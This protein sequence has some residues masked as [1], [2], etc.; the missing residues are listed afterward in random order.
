MDLIVAI[1]TEQE[2]LTPHTQQRVTV[3]WQYI[4]YRL[5]TQIIVLT[6]V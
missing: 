1:F 5:I 3:F 4:Q 2:T 6:S